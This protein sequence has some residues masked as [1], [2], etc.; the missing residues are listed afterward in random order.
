MSDGTV[1]GVAERLVT[2]WRDQLLGTFLA[3]GST[4][5]VAALAASF[6]VLLVAAA[7]GRTVRWQVLRRALFPQRLWRSASGRADIAFFLGGLF[8]S[9]VLIGWAIFSAEQVRALVASG[10]GAP[11]ARWLPGWAVGGI[12]TVV[13]FLAYEFAYWLDHML[14]HRIP[15]LWEFHKVHHQAES[16]SL[17]TNARVHP[18]ETIGFY[19]LVAVLLGGT[20][21]VL[22]KLLG[23]GVA[24]YAWGG[25]NALILLSAVA[26]TH[27]QH[28][29]LWIRFGPR[30][31]RLLLGPAH[32]QLHHSADP[33]HFG[34]N[35][36]NVLTLFDR[37]FGTF[38]MPEPRRQPLR[39][40]VDDGAAR[41][42]GVYA[43]LLAPFVSLR[44]VLAKPAATDTLT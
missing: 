11:A 22:E 35:L 16:L 17:L 34:H 33:A 6:A 44:R 5:S 1:L 20:Q 29:H 31:G 13:L 42:H 12:A 27:L 32:H 37:L 7:P 25:T 2:G 30:W 8:L 23:T 18:L 24:P 15:A 36:G 3:P 41:P 14:M 28:S 9:G 40:G 19:N 10:L 43:A 39:F 4:F 26:V 21:A 38:R